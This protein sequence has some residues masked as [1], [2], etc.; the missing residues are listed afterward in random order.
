MA[1]PDTSLD[2]TSSPNTTPSPNTTHGPAERAAPDNDVG[3]SLPIDLASGDSSRSGETDP[4]ETFPQGTGQAGPPSAPDLLAAPGHG[5]AYGTELQAGQSGAPVNLLPPA[6]SAGAASSQTTGGAPP[7]TPEPVVTTRRAANVYEPLLNE[8]PPPAS[9]G[10]LAHAGP[11]TDVRCGTDDPDGLLEKLRVDFSDDELR[12]AGLLVE[13]NQGNEVLH[14]DFAS[15]TRLFI[16]LRDSNNTVYEILGESGGHRTQSPAVSSI[17]FDQTFSEAAQA[18]GIALV[19]FSMADVLLLRSQ[20]VAAVIGTDLANLPIDPA[21]RIPSALESRILGTVIPKYPKN[22]IG[23]VLIMDRSISTG[24]PVPPAALAA[25][26]D[27]FRFRKHLLGYHTAEAHN[28]EPKSEELI[29]LRHLIAHGSEHAIMLLIEAALDAAKSLVE[30]PPPP[31]PKTWAQNFETWLLGPDFD[32]TAVQKLQRQL[33][34]QSFDL[35][36]APLL[37]EAENS[38]DPVEANLKRTFALRSAEIERRAMQ[39]L[40]DPQHELSKEEAALDR[41][42]TQELLAIA[43]TLQSANPRRPGSVTITLAGKASPLPKL[44]SYSR[45]DQP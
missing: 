42:Q 3:P 17:L 28:W 1:S 12:D 30:R 27:H 43:K 6:P 41:Q 16:A 24:D 9:E 38:S 8:C 23:Y 45:N 33:P 18:T 2:A 34:K 29:T 15:K 35:F 20:D 31:P 7:T 39:R 14:P 11:L 13:D 37:S 44:T 22:D 26:T 19:V 21:E 40:R 25:A 36:I 4:A 32:S 10:A 5:A